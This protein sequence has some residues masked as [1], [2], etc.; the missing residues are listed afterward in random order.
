[1]YRQRTEANRASSRGRLA[2]SALLRL[3]QRVK[4]GPQDDTGAKDDQQDGER[5]DRAHGGPVANSISRQNLRPPDERAASVS[6]P[7]GAN[8][9]PI[10]VNIGVETRRS[11]W[12]G[13]AERYRTATD[14]LMKKVREKNLPLDCR[15]ICL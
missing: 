13:A 11:I 10:L 7:V 1:M 9:R 3:K 5:D 15:A 8:N 6:G 12:F 14:G 4:P 2:K